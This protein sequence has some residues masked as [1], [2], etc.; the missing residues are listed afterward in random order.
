MTSDRQIALGQ[1][2]HRNGLHPSASP[3]AQGRTWLHMVFAEQSPRAGIRKN[4]TDRVRPCANGC[5]RAQ[6]WNLRVYSTGKARCHI[7]LEAAGPEW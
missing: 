7:K 2:P 6:F 5:A 4:G 3:C 1:L